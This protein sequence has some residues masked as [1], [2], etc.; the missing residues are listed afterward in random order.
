MIA[1]MVKKTWTEEENEILKREVQRYPHNI[2]W[3]VVAQHFEDHTC[4]S[5]SRTVSHKPIRHTHTHTHRHTHTDTQTHTHRHTL[6]MLFLDTAQQCLHRWL[7]SVDPEIQRGPWTP[8]QIKFAFCLTHPLCLA[9]L[10]LC[11]FDRMPA[12]RP[13]F[14]L[15]LMFAQLT[16]HTCCF[17]SA[18]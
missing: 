5:A 14:P 11:A 4:K 8:E 15:L 13:A 7:K 16:T 17:L 6:T 1:Q 2:D 18:C 12:E 3:Q 10:C 9:C